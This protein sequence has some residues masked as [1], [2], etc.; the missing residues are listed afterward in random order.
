M[1]V[2]RFD[3]WPSLLHSYLE[4]R[5]TTP[6]AYGTH[7]CC[8]FAAG[9]VAAMTGIDPAASFRNH[10]HSAFGATRR[11]REV[12]A[13]AT[14]EC[15]AGRVFGNAGFPSIYSGF[16]G[17]GDVVLIAQPNY[18]DALAVIALNGYPAVAADCGWSIA[19]RNRRI[20]A[21]RI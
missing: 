12:C 14:L 17:R 15:I 10:Y 19:G 13:C 7:D 20:A 11:M 18:G 6:F 5:R 4:S 1:N 9:A 3:H 8:L 2:R 21:W 16:A